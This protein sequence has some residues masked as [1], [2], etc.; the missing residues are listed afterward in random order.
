MT[1][2]LAL[3]LLLTATPAPDVQT[4]SRLDAIRLG[5]ARNYDLLGKRLEARRLEVLGRAA[6]RPYS[7][8][9]FLDARGRQ[10]PLGAAGNDRFIGY[11]N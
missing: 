6:W 11:V 9:V 3:A 7:P 10:T 5:V 1:P 4:I 2:A 8:T